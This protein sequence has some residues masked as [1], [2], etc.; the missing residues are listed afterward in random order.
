MGGFGPSSGHGLSAGLTPKL[1]LA[2][3]MTSSQINTDSVIELT[4]PNS[5]GAETVRSPLAFLVGDAPG[6]MNR[7]GRD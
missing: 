3:K 4:L 1:W 7:T 5:W 6:G 2:L